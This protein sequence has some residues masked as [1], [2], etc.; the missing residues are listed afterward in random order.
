MNKTYTKND[1]A[2]FNRGFEGLDVEQIAPDDLDA[3]GC[4]C[5]RGRGVRIA[6]HSARGIFPVC[7]NGVQDGGA[8]SWGLQS[9]QCGPGWDTDRPGTGVLALLSSRAED[10]DDGHF[11]HEE[12]D[13]T[14][15]IYTVGKGGPPG[16]RP[17]A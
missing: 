4:E 10:G 14:Q 8:F 16:R 13:P 1:F 17:T 5:F 9:G 15:T 7:E 12:Q 6:C 11:V 2:S 3:L